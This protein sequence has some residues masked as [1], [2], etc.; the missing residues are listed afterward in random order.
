MSE[1]FDAQTG[2]LVPAIQSRPLLYS[3]T[4]T[5]QIAEALAAAQAEMEPP[6]R[7]KEGEIKGTAKSGREYSYKYKYAPLEEIARVIREPLGK[8][9]IS[10]HQLVVTRG[11]DFFLRTYLRHS[12]G[13]WMFS[14]YPVLADRSGPQGFASG[15]TYARRY[16]LSLALGITAEDDDDAAAAQE[17]VPDARPVVTKANPAVETADKDAAR[18]A[19]LALRDIVEGVASAEAAHAVHDGKQWG[20]PYRA[21]AALV[22]EV[23]PASLLNL[24]R[25]LLQASG[26]VPTSPEPLEETPVP[27]APPGEPLRTGLDDGPLLPRVPRRGRPRKTEPVPAEA[28]IEDEQLDPAPIEEPP[29]YEPEDTLPPASVHVPFEATGNPQEWFARARTR[30]RQM[31][32]ANSP[33]HQFV[34]FRKANYGQMLRLNKEFHS[35]WQELDGMLKMGEQ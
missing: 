30:V 25:R 5:S 33:P 18:R 31:Q 2:E 9:R 26:R 7:T 3:S 27:A 29:E 23:S 16:G 28:V 17:A 1:E 35:Y 19:Y 22:A 21:A 8:Q 13:E 6:R 24:Q 20:E 34:A 12:S 10:W 4:E 15:V 32:Q 11:G 14:D